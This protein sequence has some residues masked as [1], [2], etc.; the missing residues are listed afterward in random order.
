MLVERNGR[1]PEV[2][3]AAS[4]TPTATLVGDVTV[5]AGCYLGH[6]VVVESG[7]PPVLLEP[8][9]V[10]MQNTVIR[11]VGGARRPAFPVQIGAR[12]LV[13][14]QCALAGCHLGEDCYVATQ[15]MVFQGAEVG[16]ATRLG[17]GSVVHVRTRLP[18]GSRVGLRQLAVAAPDGPLITSDLEAAR[19]ALARTDFFAEVFGLAGLEQE[20]LHRRAATILR[21][22]VL[23][24]RDRVR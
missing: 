13:G 15:V 14:P 17:A 5:A 21:E 19:A 23:G 4:I 11:S 22:E 16:S 1:R 7:G 2:D 24:W 8:D 10:V 3:P 9:V 18:A 12:T 20:E 6:G